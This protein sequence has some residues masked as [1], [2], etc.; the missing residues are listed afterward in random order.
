VS[1]MIETKIV[2]LSQLQSEETAIIRAVK[3]RGAF[4]RRLSDMGFRAGVQ[5]TVIKQAPLADPVEYLLEGCHVSLRR[6]EAEDI[7]VERLVS[8]GPFRF[9]WRR[10]KR[11][12]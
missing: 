11:Q 7:L 3:G 2:P 8:K 6:E 5:L 1:E 4:G 10:G 9:R 12:R